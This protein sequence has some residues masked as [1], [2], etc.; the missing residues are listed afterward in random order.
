M[1]LKRTSGICI[2]RELENEIFY[3]NIK[4]NLTR[5][6]RDYGTS[7]ISLHNFY[8]EDH[9]I[10]KIPRFFPIWDYVSCKIEN[11]FGSGEDIK[12]NHNIT[13]RDELQK[14]IVS[15]LLENNRGII[16][17][18]PG[19]GKTVT[20]VCSVAERKKKTFIL[21][22]R[23][24][25][26]DQWKGPGTPDKPQGFLAFTDLKEA[27]V[28]RMT[29][30]NFEDAL[31]KPIII[32]TDQTFIS[33]LKR[34]RAR[35]LIALNQANIGILIADEV[36]TTVGAPT[37][38]ECSIHIP[39]PVAFGLS[40]TPYR[41][42]GNGDIIEYHLGEVFEPEGEASVMDARVTVML[43]DYGISTSKSRTYVYW[44]G[45]FQRARYLNL[46]KKSEMLMNISKSLLTKFI[47]DNRKIIYVSE[48]I[49]HI[50]ELFKWTPTQD[51]SKF[52]SSEKIH[53]L[54]KQVTYSTPGK[55]RDG[56]DIPKKDCLIMTSPISNIE[57][58]A[59]RIIRISENKEEPIIIDMVD[60]GEKEMSKTL[61]SRV[62]YYEKKKWKVKYVLLNK[63]GGIR[64]ISKD[65][66]MEIIRGE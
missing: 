61:F 51:K 6:F 59:G 31:K 12:I 35:F 5:R 34:H 16:Q 53:V 37:F 18:S 7:T 11:K 20:G 41:Y 10:L 32:G 28:V 62:A 29:S 9:K 22:H 48:R 38:A 40:A 63:D 58:M 36:H 39:S 54:E 3:T 52:I 15:Y 24:S 4:D 14:N 21:V 19:S 49:K 26:A 55:I 44:G 65:N 33:L 17:A 46:L 47:N 45:Y 66:V 30:S 13:L 8:V 25:L 57:Q 64:E 23:D 2:P 50:E 43:F 60:V 1:I 27:E 56:V 42:D